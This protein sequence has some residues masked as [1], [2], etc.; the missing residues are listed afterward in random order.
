M[1]LTASCSNC[2]SWQNASCARAYAPLPG[3][4]RCDEYQISPAFASDLVGHVLREGGGFAIP[5]A[6]KPLSSTQRRRNS[7]RPTS[8]ARR[9]FRL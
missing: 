8:Q 2:A 6:L 9:G 4:A 5:I 3:A 1:T 7:K